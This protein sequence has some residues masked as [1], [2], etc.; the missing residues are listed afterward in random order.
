MFNGVMFA[1]KPRKRSPMPPATRYFLIV[2]V[3]GVVLWFVAGHPS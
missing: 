3:F 1:A 2:V